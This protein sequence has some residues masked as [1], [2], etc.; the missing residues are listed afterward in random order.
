MYVQPPFPLFIS[1]LGHVIRGVHQAQQTG[2]PR[3]LNVRNYNR[4]VE[5]GNNDGE[6][7]YG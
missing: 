7:L 4:R 6:L 5:A 3:I 1:K 2:T